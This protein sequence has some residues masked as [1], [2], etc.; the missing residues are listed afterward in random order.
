MVRFSG[1]SP[2]SLQPLPLAMDDL[3]VSEQRMWDLFQ[4]QIQTSQT[5]DSADVMLLLLLFQAYARPVSSSESPLT[6]L[7][8][9]PSDKWAG[10]QT[11][12]RSVCS[13]FVFVT[14]TL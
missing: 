5:Q 10:A 8:Y 9:V 7:Y 14:Y 2:L 3:R 6:S 11:M 12:L 13:T 1:G 4:D